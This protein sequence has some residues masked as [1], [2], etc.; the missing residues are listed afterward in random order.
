L[1]TKKECRLKKKT[2][3]REKERKIEKDP[4][5]PNNN[6]TVD[7]NLNLR[8]KNI[9]INGYQ[10][11]SNNSKDNRISIVRPINKDHHKD[12]IKTQQHKERT[13]F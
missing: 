1:D 4:P 2:T 13:D 11:N 9:S 7:T 6:N 10:D 3:R 12:R 8:H 5:L